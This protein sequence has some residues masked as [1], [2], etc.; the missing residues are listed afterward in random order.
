MEEVYKYDSVLRSQYRIMK[1]DHRSGGK[2]AGSHTT[3]T[4]A[5]AL[6]ADCATQLPEVSKISLGFIKAGLP[7]AKGSR[8]CKITERQGNLLLSVRDNASTQELV[9]YTEDLQKTK[10]ALYRNGL[11]HAIEVSFVKS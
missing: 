7:S 4:T 5:A 11:A 6:L 2:F 10:R 3:V 8:R 9:I 1:K